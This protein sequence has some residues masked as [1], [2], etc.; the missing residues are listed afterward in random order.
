MV[1]TSKLVAIVDDDVDTAVLFQDALQ[2]IGGIKI[3]KFTDPKIALEHF[4][5][6]QTQY[7]VVV[8]DLR[9]PNINGIELI[10]KI[11][12]L[13]PLVRTVIMTAFT[14]T[15]DHFVKY[16]KEGILN[17]FL[18]KPILLHKLLDEVN[19]QLSAYNQ[20]NPLPT[21]KLDRS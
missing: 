12:G 13:N 15:D 6:Y 17:G 18:Q 4:E 11:I 3:F 5:I 19:F 16:I 21:N 14:I 10:K 7:G 1:P 2:S 8:S 20:Y 9:M